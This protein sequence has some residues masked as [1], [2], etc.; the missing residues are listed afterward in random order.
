MSFNKIKKG[1]FYGSDTGNTE[2]VTQ[3]LIELLPFDL[4]LV[5]EA[6]IMTAGDYA[7]LDFILL[8]LST[9]YDGDLQSDFENFFE[10][11]KTID[12]TGKI[13]ALYGLGDQYG[14]ADYFIDGVGILAKEILNNG[15]RIIGLWPSGDY[16]Y[17]ES[18]AQVDEHH[19]YGLA[20]DE[21]NEM[22]KTK[23]RLEKWSRQVNEELS[24]TLVTSGLIYT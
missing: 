11:F 7:D 4:D 5:M 14:Y 22:H 16:D 2:S 3:E 8:G 15:G 18:K 19:F 12:F 23:D 21:D 17:D 6:G 10:E 24:S 1:L 20:I 9:W 13:V